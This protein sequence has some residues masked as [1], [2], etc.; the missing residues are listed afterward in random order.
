MRSV[1]DGQVSWQPVLET[2]ARSVS[3][4]S[5]GSVAVVLTGGA[6]YDG[7]VLR[8]GANGGLEFDYELDLDFEEFEEFAMPELNH[9]R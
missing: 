3:V 2:D 4:A 8:V 9:G 7:E 5:V 6:P 1:V